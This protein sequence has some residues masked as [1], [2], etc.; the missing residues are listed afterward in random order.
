MIRQ[1]FAEFFGRQPQLAVR[2]PGRIN[3]IGEHTD[4]NGGLV[5]PAAVD[6]YIFVAIAKRPDRKI[7]LYSVDFDQ[8]SL[9]PADNPQPLPRGRWENYVLGVVDGFLRRGI[10]TGGFDLAVSGNIPVGAGMSSSAALENA[11]GFALNRLFDAGLDR[12]ELALLSQQAE[13]RFAGV[14]CGIMDQFASMFG[15]NERF[16]LLDTRSLEFEYLQL[17]MQEYSLVLINTGVKHQLASSVY[18][19]RRQLC[20]LA[21]AKLGKRF[22]CEADFGELEKLRGFF[23]LEDFA[24][25]EYVL[26]ENSRVRQMREAILSSDF[27]R[28]GQLLFESHRGLSEKYR[29]S[30][31]E[32]DFLV[33]K[34]KDAADVLGARMMGGGFGGCTINLVRRGKAREFFNGLKDGYIQRFGK[35]PELI[36]VEIV[37]GT[38]VI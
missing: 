12:R 31:P 25:L 38:G 28:M 19:R 22:L 13:H 36:E 27:E 4:Y 30:C 10:E 35:E 11:V 15:R 33:E 5:M 26:E 8:F 37:D 24:A 23:T 34:A 7:G 20:E 21:A 3:L 17:P 14:R 18:N 1:K 6:K 9:H 16:L 29:V 2:S 32:L